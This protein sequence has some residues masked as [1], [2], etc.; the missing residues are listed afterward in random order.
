MRQGDETTCKA[1]PHCGINDPY[2][3]VLANAMTGEWLFF[4]DLQAFTNHSLLDYLEEQSGELETLR[5]IYPEEEF[6]EISDN[7]P[8]FKVSV[9]AA[10]SSNDKEATGTYRSRVS[11]C[12]KY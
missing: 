5:C 3:T 7:P 2:L 10:D 4:Y 1:Q 8:C 9:Q 6:T 11:T 12:V